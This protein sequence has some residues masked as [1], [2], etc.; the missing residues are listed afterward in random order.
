[1]PSVI[2]SNIN[3]IA[4]RE[5]IYGGKMGTLLFMVLRFLAGYNQYGDYQVLPIIVSLDSIALI[6]FI[7]LIK[8][9]KIK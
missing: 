4:I 9:L 1:L 2:K 8:K 5:T 3:G 7:L 6:L